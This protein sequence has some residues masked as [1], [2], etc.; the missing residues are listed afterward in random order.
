MSVSKTDS[1]DQRYD[2]SFKQMIRTQTTAESS[3]IC[4]RRRTSRMEEWGRVLGPSVSL[5]HWDT[6]IEPW[7]VIS[8]LD[9]LISHCHIG[10][11]HFIGCYRNPAGPHLQLLDSELS[12]SRSHGVRESPHRELQNGFLDTDRSL[13]SLA[14]H[15]QARADR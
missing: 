3:T 2:Q 5:C 15:T 9:P 1:G 11:L 7:H 8:F 4:G 14:S 12:T 10:D 13:R 6:D